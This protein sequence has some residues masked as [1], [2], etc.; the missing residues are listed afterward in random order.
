MLKPEDFK[1]IID[2]ISKEE[3]L[4]KEQIQSMLT[5]I[6][7]L[8]ANL[9]IV[10]YAL[11]LA[12]GNAIEVIPAVAEK[13]LS[14]SGRTDS[15]SKQKAAKYA[16]EVTARFELA[17]QMYISG[18]SEQAAEM[19]TKIASGEISMFEETTEEDQLTTAQEAENE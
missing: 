11:E 3:T 8:D 19:L 14:M 10:Q 15:K 1:E 2:T 13:V 16:A 12:V 18:A 6:Y 17:I 9:V 4:S 5:T 7:E